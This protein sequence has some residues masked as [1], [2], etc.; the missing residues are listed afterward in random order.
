MTGIAQT[1][2]QLYQQLMRA[3]Y[4]QEDLEYIHHAYDLASRLF[5]CLYRPSGKE[6]LAHAVGTASILCILHQRVS[7]IA[8]GLLHASYNHGAFPGVR[9]GPTESNRN[10]IRNLVGEETEQLIFR[11]FVFPWKKQDLRMILESI[12]NFRE[13]DRE[14]L[15]LRLVNDLEDYIDQGVSYCMRGPGI[16]RSLREIGP[17]KIE[18]AK[19][20]G[21]PALSTLLEEA[22]ATVFQTEIPSMVRKS[23]NVKGDFLQPPLSYR[24]RICGW[25]SERGLLH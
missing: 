20:L 11:Y 12:S 1:N 9:K 16:L 25:L 8:A 13:I 24:L 18:M 15:F 6:H 23:T 22:Y 4:G 10:T 17:T 7:F 2:L 19:K 3:G 5:T 21:Y 14:V